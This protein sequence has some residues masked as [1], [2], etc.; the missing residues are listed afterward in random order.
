MGGI[1]KVK[2]KL[3]IYRNLMLVPKY[4]NGNVTTRMKHIVGTPYIVHLNYSS[5]D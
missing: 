1:I 4:A 5:N 3:G 2:W